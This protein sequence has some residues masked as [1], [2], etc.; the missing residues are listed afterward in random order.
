METFFT[1]GEFNFLLQHINSYEGLARALTS[2]PS[3]PLHGM[4]EITLPLNQEINVANVVW[5]KYLLHQH[6]TR[7]SRCI[8]LYETNSLQHWNIALHYSNRSAVVIGLPTVGLK[9]S[10]LIGD[11]YKWIDLMLIVLSA[12]SSRLIT[13][14]WLQP[15]FSG[16]LLSMSLLQTSERL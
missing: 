3:E 12:K 15:R 13:L 6:T 4:N 2:S 8:G 1:D 14:P 7:A 9:H 11:T 16:K 10:P 5:H